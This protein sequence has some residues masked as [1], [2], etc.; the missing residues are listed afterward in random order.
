MKQWKKKILFL[1]PH[2][3]TGGMPAFLLKRIEALRQVYEIFVVEHRN[4]S[5]EYVVQKNKIRELVDH[6]YTL[7]G[8]DPRELQKLIT[9]NRIDI[10]HI[11]EMAES[12][13][14]KELVD[15]LYCNCRNYRIVETCHNV[16]FSPESEKKYHDLLAFHFGLN[17]RVSACTTNEIKESAKEVD[18][19]K[20]GFKINRN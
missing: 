8:D 16:S 11:D 6:F 5:N 18:R 7:K 15:A 20:I 1:A 19:R 17:I 3:S 12:L 10:V 2:L 4:F 14:D 9:S 13:G